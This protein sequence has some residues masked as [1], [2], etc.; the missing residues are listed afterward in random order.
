[1]KSLVYEISSLQLGHPQNELL[2]FTHNSFFHSFYK[3]EKQILL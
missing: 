3:I 2:K 1:M